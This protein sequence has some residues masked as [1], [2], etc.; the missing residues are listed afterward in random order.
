LN[1]I[2]KGNMQKKREFANEGK[3]GI[4]AGKNQLEIVS[5]LTYTHNDT[6]RR[7]KQ[8]GGLQNS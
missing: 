5:S 1:R 2:R 6:K 7:V 4:D 8:G 3:Y